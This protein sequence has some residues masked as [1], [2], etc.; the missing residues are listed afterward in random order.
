MS[1]KDGLELRI[2]LELALSHKGPVA[3]RYP[4]GK[5]PFHEVN[6][7]NNSFK[8]GEGEILKAG[9]DLALI[10]IGNMVYPALSVAERLEKDGVNTMVVNA[11]FIKPLDR[12]LISSV[13][14][15]VPKI[16]TIEENAL[17]GGFGSAVLEFLN[18]RGINNTKVKRL[19][20]PDIFLEQGQPGE[21]RKEYGLD[22]EGIYLNAL[23]FAKMPLYNK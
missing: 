17:Q 22:E 6:Y 16:I 10:A 4:R 9:V 1:P 8:I 5:A 11:R 13:A 20:I 2:M 23:S 19:G 18:S 21:L 7:A 12:N 15:A 3:I 14:S